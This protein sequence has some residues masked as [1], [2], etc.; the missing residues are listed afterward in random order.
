MK[1]LTNLFTRSASR[2]RPAA[3]LQFEGLEDR[4]VPTTL[5]VD[6]GAGVYLPPLFLSALPRA[7]VCH[8]R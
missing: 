6:W 5:A 3:R 4:C 2:P 7:C 8:G 1:A